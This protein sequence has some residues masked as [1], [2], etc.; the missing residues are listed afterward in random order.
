M[1]SSFGSCCPTTGN[2]FLAND[3]P[4]NKGRSSVA[5]PGHARNPSTFSRSGKF[6]LCLIVLLSLVAWGLSFF[7]EPINEWLSWCDSSGVCVSAA[8]QHQ[9]HYPRVLFLFSYASNY[10]L[11]GYHLAICLIEPYR[12]GISDNVPVSLMVSTET[13]RQKLRNRQPQPFLAIAV[14]KLFVTWPCVCRE[15]NYYTAYT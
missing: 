9:P 5:F 6:N 7:G 15:D 12:I 2:P 1:T 3:H 11:V 8:K 13:L 14:M 10:M 4:W